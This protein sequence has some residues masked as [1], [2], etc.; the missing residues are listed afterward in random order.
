[1]PFIARAK[2]LKGRVKVKSGFQKEAE[3]TGTMEEERENN[4]KKERKR[5]GL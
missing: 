4:E 2:D 1:M 3:S 5:G